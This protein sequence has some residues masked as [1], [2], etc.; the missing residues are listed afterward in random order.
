MVRMVPDGKKL[1]GLAK[2]A[3]AHQLAL[4]SRVS[5]PTV[6]KY[7]NKSEESVNVSCEVMASIL[8]FGCELTVDQLCDLRIGDVFKVVELKHDTS[9]NATSTDVLGCDLEPPIDPAVDTGIGI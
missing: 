5:Y 8:L 9:G 4:K 2:A 6:D 7:V 3:N 1:L